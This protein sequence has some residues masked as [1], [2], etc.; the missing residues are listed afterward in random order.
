M[1]RLPHETVHQ[2]YER[3]IVADAWAA[4]QVE[5]MEKAPVLYNAAAEQMLRNA[6]RSAAVEV[7]RAQTAFIEDRNIQ[8]YRAAAS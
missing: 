4:E 5:F 7:D 1:A 8:R 2:W 3:M 6:A